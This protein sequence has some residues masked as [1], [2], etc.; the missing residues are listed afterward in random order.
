M[1][2]K[3]LARAF[4]FCT[5]IFLTADV[6]LACSCLPKPS[7]LEEFERS[8]V[9]LTARIISIQKADPADK[10]HYVDGV[11]SA[12]L[13]VEKV[14]KGNVRVNDELVFAQGSGANC[15]WTFKEE[16]IGSRHLLYLNAPSRGDLWYAVGCGRSGGLT[17]VTE[18][19]LYLDNMK[20]LRGKTRVSGRLG[21]W[22]NDD[23]DVAQKKIRIVG[24]TKTYETKTDENG[25][26][27]IYDLP[28]GRYRI[29]PEMPKG[30]KIAR[31]WLRYVSGID[32]EQKSTRFVTFTLE[33]KKHASIDISF[34]PDNAV[35][36]SIVDSSGNPMEGVC[37][38]LWGPERTE[39]Y[40]PGDCTNAKGEFR[41]ES[42]GQ[43]SYVL[44]VNPY[45]ASS[46][47][48]FPRFFYPSVT[49]REKAAL[50]TIG[51]G[52]VVKN[53]NLVAPKFIETVTISGV[54]QYSDETPVTDTR[55]YLKAVKMEGIEGDVADKVDLDGRFTLTVIKGVKGE[56]YS[57]LFAGVDTYENCP[58]V[59]ALIAEANNM[60]TELKTL[61]VQIDA[62]QDVQ[63]LVL[64]FPFPK[65]KLK[66]RER[67]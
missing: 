16:Y 22:N 26:Y 52:E 9:V 19:L 18:D 30:W 31:S 65:C 67:N 21:D 15:I 64:R 51:A 34:E 27:E 62:A 58:K 56:I 20:K 44:V 6:T 23:V 17:G 28:A 1:R 32:R 7:V 57:S 36:G 42:I 10:E 55:V 8:G 66:P 46:R 29:E 63:N 54:V 50:I 4:L 35:E 40:G 33:A 3:L 5:A 60:V 48:N 43:G 38:Y 25:V 13:I 47:H 14:Y 12:T 41:I 53:I 61:P 39:G 49:Q 24:Q 2:L 11:R 45:G 37:A 59:D